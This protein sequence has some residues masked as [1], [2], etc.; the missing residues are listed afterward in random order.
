MNCIICF[1]EIQDD[2]VKPCNCK[3]GFYHKECIL[4]WIK[5]KKKYKNVCEICLQPYENISKEFHFKKSNII[6]IYLNLTFIVINIF[7]WI[8][9]INQESNMKHVLCLTKICMISVF[10]TIFNLAFCLISVLYLCT[11]DLYYID[12]KILQFYKNSIHHLNISNDV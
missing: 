3:Y 5:T 1:K 10:F 4:K 7:L 11:S 12:Y 8:S 6:L 9:Y 2:I